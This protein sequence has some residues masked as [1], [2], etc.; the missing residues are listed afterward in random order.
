M[1]VDI[2]QCLSKKTKIPF[3]LAAFHMI[4]KKDQ[5]GEKEKIKNIYYASNRDISF[6]LFSNGWTEDNNAIE[7][8][9]RP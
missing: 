8:L 5:A 3:I 4:T 2:N 6:I 7:G 9:S 1:E